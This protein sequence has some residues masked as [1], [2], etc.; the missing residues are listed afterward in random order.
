MSMV[1]VPPGAARHQ[2]FSVPHTGR[3]RHAAA[4]VAESMLL[5]LRVAVLLVGAGGDVALC[6]LCRIVAEMRRT[7][8]LLLN[9]RDICSSSKGKNRCHLVRGRDRGVLL[10]ST[11][12]VLRSSSMDS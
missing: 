5:L 11:H 6:Q 4:P 3:E 1:R 7:D 8:G 12:N 9:G 2:P 10:D